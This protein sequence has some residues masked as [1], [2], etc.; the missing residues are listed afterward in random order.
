MEVEVK[1]FGNLGHYLPDGGNRFSF[2]KTMSDGATVDQLL[3]QLSLPEGTPVLVL[4]NGRRA[5]S[6]GLLRD[7]DQVFLFSP[8]EGG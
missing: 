7:R 6:E 4:V 1:L 2:T 5:D 8:A 3:R